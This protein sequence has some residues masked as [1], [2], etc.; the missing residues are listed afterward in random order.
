MEQ[1]AKQLSEIFRMTDFSKMSKEELTEML[2]F[3]FRA[4]E[5]VDIIMRAC[6]YEINLL[7]SK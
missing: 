1:I 6:R 7:K 4:A 2:E 3:S 5:S